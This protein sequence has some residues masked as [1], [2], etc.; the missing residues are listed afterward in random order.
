[1]PI[2]NL[3]RGDS[4]RAARNVSL[5]ELHPL[6]RPGDPIA[7]AGVAVAALASGLANLP[8]VAELVLCAPSSSAPS[9]P[10]RPRRHG[11]PRLR[12]TEGSL[13]TT[14]ATSLS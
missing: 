9:Q 6:A 1:M 4:L 5:Q 2:H 11:L 12:R 7:A 8:A 3:N 14:N 13:P 10:L